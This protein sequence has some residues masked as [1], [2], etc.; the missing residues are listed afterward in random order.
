MRPLAAGSG[1]RVAAG[2]GES[3][4]NYIGV[5]LRCPPPATF[6]SL[7]CASAT[8]IVQNISY[9]NHCTSSLKYSVEEMIIC[10]RIGDR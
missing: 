3:P 10:C 8:W 4:S 2:V 9:R 5:A 7:D 6:I 1:T